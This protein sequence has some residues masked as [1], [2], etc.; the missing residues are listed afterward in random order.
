MKAIT[1]YKSIDGSR[2][3]TPE[4]ALERDVLCALIA[5][6]MIPLG[7]IPSGTNFGN[8]EGYIR[9]SDVI[10]E[11]VKVSLIGLSRPLLEEWMSTQKKQNL[12]DRH[13]SWFVRMLDDR[14]EP[15]ERAWTRLWCIDNQFREWGQ[16]YYANH[17]N[18]AKQFLLEKS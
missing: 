6:A 5:A 1:V 10:V 3:D 13:P 8:G 9:H 18:E 4:Q 12:M 7:K 14:A 17:P 16:P 2:R 15:L 11:Q